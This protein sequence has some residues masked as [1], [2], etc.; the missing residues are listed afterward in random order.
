[1]CDLEYTTVTFVEEESSPICANITV[2][3]QQYRLKS[4]ARALLFNHVAHYVGFEVLGFYIFQNSR[5]GGNGVVGGVHQ[6]YVA[7]FQ[8]F[9]CALVD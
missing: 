6:N 7:G 8:T 5:Q 4:N 1:M 9:R 3:T 2:A